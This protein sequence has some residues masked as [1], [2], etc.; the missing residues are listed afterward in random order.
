MFLA[1]TPVLQCGDKAVFPL[2]KHTAPS[3]GCSPGV[4]TWCSGAALCTPHVLLADL[5]SCRGPG[6]WNTLQKHQL[7]QK[8]PLQQ[9]SSCGAASDGIQGFTCH[10]ALN[11]FVSLHNSYQLKMP[12]PDFN[13]NKINFCICQYRKKEVKQPGHAQSCIQSKKLNDF[14]SYF[15]FCYKE[16]EFS[17]FQ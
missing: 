1:V 7:L 2:N 13:A 15:Q 14:N 4:R 9:P 11:L 8:H 17:L 6:Y 3:C 12:L 5:K 10:L 16:K